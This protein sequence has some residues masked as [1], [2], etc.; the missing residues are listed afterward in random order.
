MQSYSRELLPDKAGT[1][2]LPLRM[3]ISIIS[4]SIILS[5][6]L[7]IHNSCIM[8]PKINARW[9]PETI[10]NEK[11][12]EI[13]VYVMAD[14]KPLKGAS[15]VIKGFGNASANFTDENGIAKIWIEPHMK[16]QKEG[17]LSILIREQKC[18]AEFYA[19]RGI[20]VVNADGGKCK[21]N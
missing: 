18:H 3:V 19:E 6:L 1:F 16:G 17:Y 21:T 7:Y 14:G 10:E 11:R 5:S 15:V 2:S 4:G 20:R 12:T 8:P 9:E 13:M